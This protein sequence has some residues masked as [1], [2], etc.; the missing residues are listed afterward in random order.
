MDSVK[1]ASSWTSKTHGPAISEMLP[2]TCTNLERSFIALT[3]LGSRKSANASSYSC[4]SS[5]TRGRWRL[6]WVV[7]CLH[8]LTFRL[9]E[10]LPTATRTQTAAVVYVPLER[11]CW[12]PCLLSRSIF[13]RTVSSSIVLSPECFVGVCISIIHIRWGSVYPWLI[14]TNACNTSQSSSWAIANVSLFVAVVKNP[15]GQISCLLRMFPAV[16]LFQVCSRSLNFVDSDL[17]AAFDIM[18]REQSTVFELFSSHCQ[19]PS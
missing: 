11:Y 6:S 8:F 5:S 16:K 18:F 4:H 1:L 9:N 15:T 12:M 2:E 14:T 19:D 10:V 7:T 17:G 3:W 13:A